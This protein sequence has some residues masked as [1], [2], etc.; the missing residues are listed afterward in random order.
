MCYYR[1]RKYTEYFIKAE[2]ESVISV[3]FSYRVTFYTKRS[4]WLPHRHFD[5]SG[6]ISRQNGAGGWGRLM[7]R[8]GP[9]SEI[10]ER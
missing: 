8:S 5:Q 10:E 7:A 9:G 6:E 4:G 1:D 2:E 3:K